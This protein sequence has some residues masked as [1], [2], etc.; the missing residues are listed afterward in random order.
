MT[1]KFVVEHLEQGVELR[2]ETRV[3]RLPLIKMHFD[4]PE[5]AFEL[6]KKLKEEFKARDFS[7]RTS[8]AK[9]KKRYRFEILDD[10][11]M[12]VLESRWYPKCQSAERGMA[13]M[14]RTLKKAEV[15]E[16]VTR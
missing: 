12:L 7:I 13:S 9:K 5:E 16:I 15:K 4:H 14:L 8:H 10:N 6:I 1:S 3:D 11:R 2:F